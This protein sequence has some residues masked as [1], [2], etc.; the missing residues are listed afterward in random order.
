MKQRGVRGARA[1]EEA[2]LRH[3]VL[4]SIHSV[5]HVLPADQG[6]VQPG[7][8]GTRQVHA[9]I[10]LEEKLNSPSQIYV[11]KRLLQFIKTAR[12]EV[13]SY[14]NDQ[15]SRRIPSHFCKLSH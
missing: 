8:C 14:L 9:V 2:V 1:A 12:P 15:I 5:H 11:S 10:A 3:Q 13:K 4:V 6:A 7:V